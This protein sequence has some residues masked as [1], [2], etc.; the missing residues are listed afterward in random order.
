[1]PEVESKLYE[2]FMEGREKGQAIRREW[3]R[4]HFME[5][6]LSVYPN[7]N[8]SVLRF[9]NRWFQ[10]FLER[11]QISLR[12]LPED[13]RRPVINWLIFNRRNSQPSSLSAS[14]QSFLPSASFIPPL[15][16]FATSNIFNVDETPLLFEYLNGYT[17]NPKGD[18]TIWVKETR[19]GWNKRM[20]SLVLCVFADGFNRVPPLIIFHGKGNVYE[21]EKN[22]YHPGILVEFNEEAYMNEKLFYRYLQEHVIPVLVGRPSL[23]ALDLCSAH[24]TESVLQLLHSNHIIPS[25]IPASCT[26]LVQPLDVSIN[27]PLKGMT[28]ELT[29]E[30]ILDCESIEHFEKWSVG[31]RRILTTNCVRDTWYQFCIEKKGLVESVFRKVGLSLPADGSRDNELDI[32]G[33][34]GIEMGDWRIQENREQLVLEDTVLDDDNDEYIVTRK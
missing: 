11:H 8:R 15:N 9:S 2:V 10:G 19:S 1:W 3:F 30:A 13:Y 29:D 20:A 14:S 33:F 17:Y 6:F 4:R 27:K 32:K 21:K 18:K 23:F 25:L 24:K 5:I 31:Q 34:Q 16:R 12:A 7:T 22:L 26:S 28:R